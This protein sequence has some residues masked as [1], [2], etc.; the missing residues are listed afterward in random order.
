MRLKIV[1]DNFG[2]F[3]QYFSTIMKFKPLAGSSNV[4]VAS[5][6][7][8]VHT[9]WESLGKFLHLSVPLLFVWNGIIKWWLLP[10]MPGRRRGSCGKCSNQSLAPRDVPLLAGTPL[11]QYKCLQ[12]PVW[13][14]RVEGVIVPLPPSI[15]LLIC[16]QRCLSTVTTP[17]LASKADCVSNITVLTCACVWAPCDMQLKKPN[18]FLCP[19]GSPPE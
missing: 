19:L 9:S 3:W 18:S 5:S 17:E 13:E 12:G 16:K 2:S 1:Q 11:M 14:A 8:L 6:E 15:C 7:N 10:G 4:D